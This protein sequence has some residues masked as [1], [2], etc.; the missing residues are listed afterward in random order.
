MDGP[1]SDNLF[2]SCLPE[3]MDEAQVAEVF[4]QYGTVMNCK[5]VSKNNA[6]FAALVRFSSIDEAVS[7]KNQLNGCVPEGLETP[8]NVRFANAKGGGKG[9]APS[10]PQYSPG[11][12]QY[13]GSPVAHYSPYPTSPVK[14]IASWDQGLYQGKGA[15]KGASKGVPVGSAPSKGAPIGSA[16]SSNAYVSSW[17]QGKGAAAAAD[18]VSM[19]DVCK[20]LEESG[21]LPGGTMYQ[22]NEAAV[23]VAGLPPDCTDNHLWRMFGSFGPTAPRG[24]KAMLGDLGNCKGFGF[25]NYLEVASAQEAIK[26]LNGMIMPSG[27]PLQVKIKTD[28]P[29]S[30]GKGVAAKGAAG[31]GKAWQKGGGW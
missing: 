9:K 30:G 21:V 13:S 20:G 23:F 31:K 10:Q 2:I 12:A 24:V 3:G 4:G 27:K 14:K 1:P 26:T 6:E 15:S 8:V 22:N 19:D 28:Q 25:V 5:A 11:L 29:A 16:P 17:D 18:Q 7:V